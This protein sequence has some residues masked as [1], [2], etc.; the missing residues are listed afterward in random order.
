VTVFALGS[1]ILLLLTGSLLYTGLSAQLDHAIDQALRDRAADIALDLREGN[2]QI[3]PGE[4]YVVL[5]RPDGEVVDATTVG[6][7]RTPVLSSR[8]LARARKHE[9]VFERSK[10]TGLGDRGRLLARPERVA[11]GSVVI[12]VVG[13]SLDTVTRASPGL[14]L[15]LAAASLLL[16]GLIAGSGWMLAGAALRPVRRMIH[17]AAAISLVQGG[18]R[19]RQPPGDDEIA[20]LGRTL[21]VMLDRIETSL[22][23]ERAF[24]DDASHELRT[25]LSILRGEL[26]LAS[27]RPDDV[28]GMR[29]ALLSALQEAEHLGQLTEDLLVLARTDQGGLAPR[30][31]E[32]DLLETARRA[33]E[34]HGAR[35]ELAVEVVG[36]RVVVLADGLLLERVVGNLIDNA[37]RHAINAVEVAVG[38]D[39]E[40]GRLS[41][42]DDGV[43]FPAEFLPVAF[44][45]FSRSDA[46]RGG[47]DGG[48]GLGLAI[49]AELVR[50]Q[51]G[52]VGI[53]ND[54]PAG[55]GRVDVWFPFGPRP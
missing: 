10:V 19:L 36:I 51:G 17:E 12:V 43:G 15:L 32:V 49:V 2:L 47:T 9:I 45:R 48:S 18:E 8:E 21:N 20:L 28:A 38:I 23:H 30:L 25:P 55:G 37:C 40:F 34:R 44:D 1:S 39:G 4:P 5:L 53:S 14:G 22:A 35:S 29:R 54:G 42:S 3:R 27:G 46:A 24:V 6:A 41:V 11:D 50:A 13:E 16:I 26:E 7:R 52:R 31:D 33:A